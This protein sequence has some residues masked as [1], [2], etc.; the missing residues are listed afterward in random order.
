MASFVHAIV[1]ALHQTR[2][3]GHGRM[4]ELGHE[5]DGAGVVRHALRLGPRGRCES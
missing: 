3:G 4:Q 2:V 1:H 5:G